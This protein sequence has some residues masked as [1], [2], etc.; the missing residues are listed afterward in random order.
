MSQ[1]FCFH[2]GAGVPAGDYGRQ[3]ACEKCGRDVHV[4]KNCKNYDPRQHNECMEPQADRVVEKEK[5]NFCDWWKPREGAGGQ[6]QSRDTLKSAAD[7]LFKKK[8]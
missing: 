7:A 5:A 3:A 8:L 4:C 1:L 2:C 6:S